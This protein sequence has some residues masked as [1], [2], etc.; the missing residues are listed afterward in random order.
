VRKQLKFFW[1]RG[2]DAGGDRQECR[3]SGEMIAQEPQNVLRDGEHGGATRAVLNGFV[4][5]TA[6]ESAMRMP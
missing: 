3:R 6:S 1:P 5:L 4:V 2:L